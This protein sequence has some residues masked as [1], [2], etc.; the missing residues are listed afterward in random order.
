MICAPYVLSMLSSQ[1]LQTSAILVSSPGYVTTVDEYNF[2]P[3]L[4]LKEAAFHSFRKC[5]DSG[6]GG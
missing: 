6:R 3:P 5:L 2:L 1:T 4:A